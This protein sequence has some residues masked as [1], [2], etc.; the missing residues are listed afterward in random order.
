MPK[1][2]SW[3]WN[4]RQRRELRP[5]VRDDDSIIVVTFVLGSG[6]AGLAGL[7]FAAPGNEFTGHTTVEFATAGILLLLPAAGLA[8]FLNR[9]IRATAKA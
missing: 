4:S 9:G 1:I 3:P 5:G 8:W 2:S 6:F 7:L